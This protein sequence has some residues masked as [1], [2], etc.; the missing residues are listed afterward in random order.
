MKKAV[1]WLMGERGGKATLATWNWLWGISE[2]IPEPDREVDEDGDAIATAEAS[3]KAMQ[4]SVQQLA[5]ATQQQYATYQQAKQLYLRKVKALE[6]TEH[7]ALDAE[8]EGRKQDAEAAIT[9]AMQLEQLLPTLEAKVEQAEKFVN[10]SQAKLTQERARLE[11]YKSDLQALKNLT[12]INDALTA[13]AET[14][15]EEDMASARAQ[16]EEAKNSVQT[17]YLET[18]A[19]VEL[20]VNPGDPLEADFNTVEQQAEVARRLQ[21]LRERQQPPGKKA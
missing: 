4:K 8:K 21:I 17:R 6:R 10:A 2:D 3:F 13:I 16:F 5:A 9:Y 14:H 15:N 18:R 1:Y 11:S 12:E 20:S 19:Y 7:S